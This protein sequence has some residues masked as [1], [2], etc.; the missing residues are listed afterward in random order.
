MYQANTVKYYDEIYSR[1]KSYEDEAAKV[2][3][4]IEKLRPDAKTLL[5]VACGTAE[6]ARFLK[7]RYR[8]DGLYLAEHL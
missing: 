8:I 6:H 3:A 2:Q 7:K 4:W 1:I 5:D